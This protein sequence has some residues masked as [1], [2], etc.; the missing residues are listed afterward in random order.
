MIWPK[1][2]VQSLRSVIAET[3]TYKYHFFA[4]NGGGT[5]FGFYED[6]GR[7]TYVSAPDIGAIVDIKEL[8]CWCEFM[9]CLT[10]GEYI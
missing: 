4:S 10:D 6:R 2:D 7:F 9:D 8:G 5:Q 1:E 3:F